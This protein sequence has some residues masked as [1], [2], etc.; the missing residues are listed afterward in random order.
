MFL[1]TSLSFFCTGLPLLCTT[2]PK[3]SSQAAAIALKG[4][5]LCTATDPSKRPCRQP[6][7]RKVTPFTQPRSTGAKTTQTIQPK[8]AKTLVSLAYG[9]RYSRRVISTGSSNLMPRQKRTSKYLTLAEQRNA[10]VQSIERDLDLGNG[11]ST[12]AYTRAIEDLRQ[13]LR[14]Y[15]E[16]LSLLDQAANAVQDAEQVV[17]DFS[18]R[19]LLG[20]ATKYGKDSNEYEMA[21]GVRKSDRK[22]P[23][24]KPKLAA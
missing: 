3:A 2:T 8:S 13:K 1:C 19:I 11:I 20:V 21:G 6:Y 9:D 17:R 14:D 10:G 5:T 24:R 18:E 12:T 4:D 22:R 23:T 15:N 7:W 16:S